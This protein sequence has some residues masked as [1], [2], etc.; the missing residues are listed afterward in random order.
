[1]HHAQ[2][3]VSTDEE[4]MGSKY[5]TVRGVRNR[6]SPHLAEAHVY[7]CIGVKNTD[8]SRMVAVVFIGENA[9]RPDARS[10]DLGAVGSIPDDHAALEAELLLILLQ[11]IPGGITVSGTE[12]GTDGPI[13]ARRKDI[14]A[15]AVP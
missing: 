14:L 7:A 1:M 12:Y 5:V 15:S 10:Y 4:C 13:A 3:H 9:R 2:V 6:V 8:P 11:N